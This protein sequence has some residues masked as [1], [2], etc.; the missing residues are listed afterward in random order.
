MATLA[1]FCQTDDG[2]AQSLELVPS[3]DQTATLER[4]SLVDPLKVL[5]QQNYRPPIGALVPLGAIFR[6]AGLGQMLDGESL[7]AVGNLLDS[8]RAVHAFA[9]DFANRCSTLRRVK[10]QILP[11]PHLAQAINRAVGPSGELLDDASEHLTRIRRQKLTLRRRIE[12]SVTKL[13][14]DDKDLTTYLQDDFFTVRSERYVVPM[15]LDGRGRVKG[16]ILDTST[17]GQTLYIEPAAIAPMNDQL[18]EFDL[19]EKLEIARIFRELSSMVE[20]D[21]ETLKS[22][23]GELI[24][25]DFL[26]AQAQLASEIAAGPVKLSDRPGI[27]LRDARHPLLKKNSGR[28][29][30]GNTIELKDSQSVLIISGPN[31]GGKTVVLKTV[32]LLHLMAKAGL[33]LPAEPDSEVYLYDHVYLEMGD[34]QNLSANLSTF[35]GHLTGL[36]PILE[37][38]TGKDL[39]LLDELAVGTDPETGAAIGTAILEE[40]AKRR[41]TSLVTTHYDALKGLA[42]SDNRFRNG[43][44]EYSLGNLKPTYKLILDIPGQSYGLEVAEQIGLKPE[45]LARAK[46]LRGGKASNLDLAVSELMRARDD[47]R[48]VTAALAKERLDAAA[49]KA[50]WQQEVELLKEQ[51]RKTSQQL[52]D[53]FEGQVSAMKAEYDELVKKLRQTVKEAAQGTT[54]TGLRDD[55]LEGRRGAEKALRDLDGVVNELSAGYDP[56]D[57]LPGQ[58]VTRGDLEPNSPVYVLPLKKAGKVLRLGAGSDETI[59]VEVGVIKLRVSLH[60]LRLLS[61]GEV[62]GGDKKKAAKSPGPRLA[63]QPAAA[64]KPKTEIGLVIQTPLNST[65][66]RGR[67]VTGAI[68][69]AW[70]FIDRALLRGEESVILIHGHGEGTLKA[71]VRDALRNNCPYDIR[72][73][74]GLD[75]EG[76]D[77]VTVVLLKI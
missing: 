74:P 26:A 44:M 7:R 48:Q 76:G 71:A 25:L 64:P 40:L 27:D 49:E 31:A 39:A 33:L 4:W 75:Q 52:A 56:G 50:R 11:M 62:P 54:P 69:A 13:I 3:L 58:P 47:A 60:D 57:K 10:G 34:A 35:S 72:F 21:R 20:V 28:T 37:Q 24:Q 18:L 16:A 30:I 19:E 5:A 42:V 41:V 45:V 23:Y 14:H 32:G 8:T 22:N 61:A 53:K 70:N 9:S 77:G 63:P 55:V 65:D 15:K 38:A 12:E 29:P 51:R 43:S 73:R 59:E 36:K 67:D 1:G 17:S 66:L 2:R 68:E 46:E 6:A